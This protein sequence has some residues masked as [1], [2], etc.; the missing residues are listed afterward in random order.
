MNSGLPATTSLRKLNQAQR[1]VVG[2]HW[3][4]GNIRMPLRS[5]LFL[6]AQS[7]GRLPPVQLAALDRADC[8]DLG[9]VP[10]ELTGVVEDGVDVKP[11]RLGASCQLSEPQDEL[12]L[13]V[14]GELVLRAEEDDAT[15][16]DF[17][18]QAMSVTP[19]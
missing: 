12:L 2:W 9:V 1:G 13:K 10:A 17:R 7:V 6:G 14:V 16:G 19:I 15:L 3:L 4:E 18:G 11:G 8:A 5:R